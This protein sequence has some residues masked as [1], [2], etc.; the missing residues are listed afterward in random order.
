MKQFLLSLS[1]ILSI[2]TA[3]IAQNQKVVLCSD[4]DK[5]NGTPS[6]INPDWDIKRDGGCFVYII[7]SQDK[8]IA[9]TISLQVDKKNNS[10]NKPVKFCITW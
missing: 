9:Q 10:G 2:T 7:Y 8:P 5:D 4:Y 6:G 1:L 3:T